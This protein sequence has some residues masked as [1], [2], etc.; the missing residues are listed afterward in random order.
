ML[1]YLIGFLLVASFSCSPCRWCNEVTRV[2]DSITINHVDTILKVTEKIIND[3]AG[4]TLFLA[5]DSLNGLIIK[6]NKLINGKYVKIVYRLKDSEL[7]IKAF[8][9]SL[10]IKD[11]ELRIEKSKVKEISRVVYKEKIIKKVPWYVRYLLIQ[12]ILCLG[13]FIIK[14]LRF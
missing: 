7:K 12:F 13:Y 6:E 10:S 1:K 9:D 14:Y 3:S 8:I 4:F 11:K 2:T 5:C